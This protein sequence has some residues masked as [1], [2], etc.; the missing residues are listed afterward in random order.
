[1]SVG[2]HDSYQ[3]QMR[4]L[5]GDDKP[6]LFVGARCVVRDDAGRVLL[7]RRSDNGEWALPAGAMELGE[8]IADCAARELFEET[9]LR[10]T[11]VVPFAMHSGPSFT[12]TNMYGHTY[13]VFATVFLVTSWT[14]ALLTVTDET[15]DAR[16]VSVD[17]L[18]DP[19]S[20]SVRRSLDDL[21]FYQETGDFVAK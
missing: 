14:G 9:G 16:F 7:V 10:A 11:S 6:L 5:A 15:T 1:M 4:A 20:Q 12:G 17:E 2:W 3:G 19:L 13:Q 21:V 8:S 18:P